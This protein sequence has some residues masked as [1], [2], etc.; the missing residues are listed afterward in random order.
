MGPLARK[1]ETRSVWPRGGAIKLCKRVMAVERPTLATGCTCARNLQRLAALFLH[2]CRP[3][4]PPRTGTSIRLDS[5][6]RRPSRPL[7]KRRG[8]LHVPAEVS[9]CPALMAARLLLKP[10]SPRA[11]GLAVGVVVL[12][13]ALASGF[14]ALF[15]GGVFPGSAHGCT[16][17]LAVK[18]PP[19]AP[20]WPPKPHRGLTWGCHAARPRRP[21]SPGE[22]RSARR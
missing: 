7:R 5:P 15:L 22:V 19:C 20:E 18:W 3:I 21:P 2:W 9:F 13:V 12:A 10:C 6:P 8:G 11:D 16:S 1:T 14:A 17:S 4:T